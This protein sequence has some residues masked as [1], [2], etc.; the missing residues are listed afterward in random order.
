M[1]KLF[2]I[3]IIFLLLAKLGFSQRES[4]ILGDTSYIH[5]DSINGNKFVTN[6]N[7]KV[8]EI[9]KYGGTVFLE[10]FIDYVYDKNQFKLY[11]KKVVRKRETCIVSLISEETMVYDT[12]G[13]F[14]TLTGGNKKYIIKKYDRTGKLILKSKVKYPDSYEWS[15]YQFTSGQKK[16]K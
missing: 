1:K 2:S 5:I 4:T 8:A 10:T 16:K 7:T 9:K 12:T 6:C 15:I 3:L 11:E 13:S 14:K